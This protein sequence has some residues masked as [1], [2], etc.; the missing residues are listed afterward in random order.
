MAERFKAAVLKITQPHGN[1]VAISI[2]YRYAW[3]GG[4]T[5]AEHL[6]GKVAERLKAP[7]LKTGRVQA[8]AGSNPALSASMVTSTRL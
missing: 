4:G 7:V 2:S 1:H 8:L 6:S 3:V 5:L